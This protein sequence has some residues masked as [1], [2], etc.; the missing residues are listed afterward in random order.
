MS[1][2]L[3]KILAAAGLG[4]RRELEDWIRAGRITIDGRIATLGDRAN[5]DA[6]I[7]VDGKRLAVPNTAV[8][9]V[10]VYNKPE[11]VVCTRSDPQGRPTIFDKLPRLRS[12]RWVAIGRLDIN[13]T[14]LLLL[15]TDGELANR[16]MHPTAGIER[17]YRVRVRGPVTPEVLR[18]LTAGVD[19][20]DGP[21]RFERIQAGAGEGANRWFSVVLREGRNREV[22]RLWASQGCTVSRLKRIRY[23]RVALPSWVRVGQWVELP[24]GEVTRLY[25]D[26]G[27]PRPR[28]AGQAAKLRDLARREKR[29]RAGG[30]RRGSTH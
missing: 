18:R 30:R 28:I 22:R 27:L 14:G 15:T 25:A 19:L 6:L 8:P 16:L 4:S 13:T 9:R 10:L 2:K 29:L 7:C 5:R 23:G 1:E 12:G 3:Q 17:E 11:G 21:G 24:P 20:D 26:A